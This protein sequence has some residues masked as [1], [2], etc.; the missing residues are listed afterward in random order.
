[1]R[2]AA[3][4]GGA[5]HPLWL[6]P[7]HAAALHQGRL[8]PRVARVCGELLPAGAHAPGVLLPR[9]GR[10]RGADRHGREDR[11]H[12]L[13]PA[14][15]GQGHG[16]PDGALR[17]HRA[18]RPGR[19]GAVPV[20]RGRHGGHRHRVAA[21][22]VPAVGAPPLRGG[23]PVGAG[24]PG[25]GARVGVA[26]GARGAA[27]RPGGAHRAGGGVPPAAGGP[28]RDAG[29]GAAG[30]RPRRQPARQP[31]PPHRKRAARQRVLAAPPRRHG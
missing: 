21:R 18:Q 2:G 27:R 17:R 3:E 14:P 6:L 22:G 28:A 13:H 15:P 16:G 5:A 25:V 20:R 10:A 1:V 26:R 11:L 12:G 31:A 7:A 9:H 8:R 23:L 30:G 4:R 24:P 19:G 29:R